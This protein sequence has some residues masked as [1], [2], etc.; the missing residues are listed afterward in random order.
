MSHHV[1]IAKQKKKKEGNRNDRR[2]KDEAKK[3]RRANGFCVLFVAEKFCSIWCFCCSVLLLLNTQ[4]WYVWVW[5]DHFI[6]MDIWLSFICDN[7]FCAVFARCCRT[8]YIFGTWEHTQHKIHTIS[9]CLPVSLVA[10][11]QTY[12]FC[13]HTHTRSDISYENIK[14]RY[15]VCSIDPK[16][17]DGNTRQKLR[18]WRTSCSND[19]RWPPKNWWHF[20][21]FIF[22]ENCHKASLSPSAV[23]TIFCVDGQHWAASSHHHFHRHRRHHWIKIVFSLQRT[24]NIF[25]VQV[26]R[27]QDVCRSP[28]STT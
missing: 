2:D 3:Q 8:K 7:V 5:M 19:N 9:L 4:C 14:C 22:V 27:H 18:T 17:Y 13:A 10:L 25:L 20:D 12:V 21:K 16:W 23:K 24:I 28:Q 11:C 26:L 6:V 1:I 15:N